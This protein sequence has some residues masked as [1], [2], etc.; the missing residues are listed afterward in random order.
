M[1]DAYLLMHDCTNAKLAYDTCE[2]RF[3]REK[4]GGEAKA[5]IDQIGKNPP[6]LCAPQ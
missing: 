2:K 1:G 5:K 3:T 4:I 6:G